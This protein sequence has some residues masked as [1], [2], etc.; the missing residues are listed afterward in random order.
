MVLFN[1]ETIINEIDSFEDGDKWDLFYTSLTM[2]IWRKEHEDYKGQGL[3]VYKGIARL[4]NNFGGKFHFY[5]KHYFSIWSMERCY[6]P[7]FFPSTD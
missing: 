7:G 1:F 5:D 4:P 6:R 3:Y 2:K